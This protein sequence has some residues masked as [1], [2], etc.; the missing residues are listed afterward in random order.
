MPWCA[1]RSVQLFCARSSVLAAGMLKDESAT[2]FPRSTAPWPR[3]SP[4]SAGG[5]SPSAPSA[6]SRPPT[7]PTTPGATSSTTCTFGW[8]SSRTWK[9][10]LQKWKPRSCARQDWPPPP[11]PLTPSPSPPQPQLTPLELPLRQPG[12][13]GAAIDPCIFERWLK[14]QLDTPSLGAWLKPR[15]E[16]TG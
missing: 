1:H 9:G 10:P 6:S 14:P 8:A 7:S 4:F 12:N 15:P 13:A 3:L 2:G 16:P 11:P 5:H